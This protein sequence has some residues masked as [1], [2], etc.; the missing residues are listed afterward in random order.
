M[1]VTQ[2]NLTGVALGS[3]VRHQLSRLTRQPNSHIAVFIEFGYG[4]S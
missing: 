1:A 4:A 2:N 3:K